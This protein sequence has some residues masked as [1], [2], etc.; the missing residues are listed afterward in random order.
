M[1]DRHGKRAR[2]RP[3]DPTKRKALLA[4]AR[5][6]FL[7]LGP[8][9][10]TLDQVIARAQVSRATFYANFAEKHSLLAAVI[11][12]ESRRIVD[13][14]W[15][16]ERLATD[17]RQALIEF[18]E[19]L[20]R[21]VAEPDTL[22]LERLIGQMTRSQPGVG[23]DCFEA[24][25][26]RARGILKHIIATGQAR[27]ELRDAD[28]MQAAS[29]LIGLWEGFWRVEVGYGLRTSPDAEERQRR[30]RHGVDQFY[31]LYGVSQPALSPGNN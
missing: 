18:G 17:L 5:A 20:L 28:P 13:D 10:V 31:R 3:R 9:L 2:G 25:P 7:E 21:F 4:A 19:R 11:A 14:D 29:D 27:G 16:T 22:A 1:E 23:V 12:A 26:G 30:A 24:G 8:D 15:A 6:L